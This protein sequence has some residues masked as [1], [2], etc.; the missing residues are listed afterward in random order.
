[1]LPALGWA[2]LISSACLRAQPFLYVANQ[3]A[4][5]ISV[6]NTQNNGVVRT[7][8]TPFAPA[9]VAVVPDG[10]R[11]YVVN[12]SFN[13]MLVI[14]LA[15][16]Q[17]LTN[18]GYGQQNPVA[19][20]VS[21]NGQRIYV[22]NQV[23][24]TVTVVNGTT[25]A[26]V[27]NV[28]VG[29]TPAALA[30]HPDGSRLYVANSSDDTVS[31]LNTGTNRVDAT[32]DGA[33][34]TPVGLAVT[35]DGNWL[36]VAAQGSQRLVRIDT[37]RELASGGIDLNTEPVNIAFSPDGST[38]YASTAGSTSLLVFD[39]AGAT[40]R[41]TVALPECLNVRCAAFGVSV[42]ADGKTVYVAD[43][44]SNQLHVVNAETRQL[45]TSVRT[46]GGP[47]GIALGPVP[48][49]MAAAEGGQQ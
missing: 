28:R 9:A 39:P 4:D 1:M 42:S 48:R 47:R 45:A 43:A 13:S 41:E 24:G 32:I 33:G 31:V 23:S 3:T 11:A 21:A 27:A 16:N 49:T 14:N 38:G 37:R 20:A 19:V 25:L 10:S 46:D 36:Y 2:L 34:S 35:P 40:L 26:L 29:N 30:L 6:V 44:S 5:S 7:F 18:V 17:V 12:A 8:P 22:A 15:T